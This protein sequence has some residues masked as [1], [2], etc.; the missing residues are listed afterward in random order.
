MFNYDS[1]KVIGSL[2]GNK[3]ITTNPNIIC[4]SGCRD[5]QT[6]A[7]VY[8]PTEAR[9]VGAFTASFLAALR[10]NRINVDIMKLYSD[11]CAI[12]LSS[13]FSQIPTLSCSTNSPNYV[14]QRTL[15]NIISKTSPNSVILV[16]TGTT[17]TAKDLKILPIDLVK[18]IPDFPANNLTMNFNKSFRN[19]K[20]KTLN[21][22]FI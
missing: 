6:S 17:T 12:I 2:N 4:F 7:D 9:S 13:G 1:G 16:N 11:L 3:S 14:F 10:K 8:L 15:N 21:M 18:K 20:S 22:K 19:I 5:S